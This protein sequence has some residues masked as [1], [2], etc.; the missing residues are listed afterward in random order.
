MSKSTLTT[1]TFGN[2]FLTLSVSTVKIVL[3]KEP[4]IL[5]IV[6]K[7]VSESTVYMK[8]NDKVVSMTVKPEILIG[9]DYLLQLL[10][11]HGQFVKNNIQRFKTKLGN[12]FISKNSESYKINIVKC[13]TSYLISSG[14]ND[15]FT[16]SEDT[17]LDDQLERFSV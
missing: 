2:Q 5:T 6:P 1:E 15:P 17:K 14:K 12:L 16:F 9:M 11:F 13:L 10:G 3:N 7:I 4:I 8:E